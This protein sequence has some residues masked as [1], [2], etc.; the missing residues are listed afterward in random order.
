MMKDR[1][2]GGLPSTTE[3]NSR[4][5]VNAVFTRTVR[6]AEVEEPV[7]IEAK[8]IEKEM[9][10]EPAPGKVHIT[11]LSLAS[12]AQPK[13]SE[14]KISE[15]PLRVYKPR[16]PYPARLHANKGDEQNGKFFDMLKQLHINIPFVEALM[17]MPKYAKFLKDMLTNK[18]KLEEFSTVALTEDCSALLQKKLPKKI[19]DPGSFTIPCLLGNISTIATRPSCSP[20]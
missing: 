19:D 5:F 16:I 20:P 14:E 8:P 13:E 12:I 15:A 4:G 7:M 2:A 9:E 11:R 6:G 18:K 17:S 1:K 3:T 10:I